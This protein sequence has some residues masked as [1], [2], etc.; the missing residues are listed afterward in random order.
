MKTWKQD[1]PQKHC[2]WHP[3]KEPTENIALKYNNSPRGSNI[4]GKLTEM[5]WTSYETTTN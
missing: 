2:L 4:Y 5:S 3:Y 1:S